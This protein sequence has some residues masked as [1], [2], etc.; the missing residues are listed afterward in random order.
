MHHSHTFPAMSYNP[1]I[2][3]QER[4]FGSRHQHSDLT[5]NSSCSYQQ[6]CTDYRQGRH[7]PTCSV[8]QSAHRERL[9]P[10]PLR[11][12]GVYLPTRHTPLHC[13]NSLQSQHTLQTLPLVGIVLQPIRSAH[14]RRQYPARYGRYPPHASPSR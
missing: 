1:D 12:A 14:H 7:L 11:S 8:P 9:S 6:S 2:D 13:T 4:F 3:P 10:T 5:K